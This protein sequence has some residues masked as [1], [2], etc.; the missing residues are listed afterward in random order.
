MLFIFPQLTCILFN[1]VDYI[2]PLVRSIR[3][4]VSILHICSLDIAICWPASHWNNRQKFCHQGK[5]SSCFILYAFLFDINIVFIVLLNS[6]KV[7]CHLIESYY[8]P[9]FLKL[10]W[11]SRSN[12][13]ADQ[14]APCPVWFNSGTL[15]L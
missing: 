11:T 9:M 6:C 4:D 13:L 10:D 7:T 14:P 3:M 1:F 15:Y 12:Q 8:T 2:L 5:T